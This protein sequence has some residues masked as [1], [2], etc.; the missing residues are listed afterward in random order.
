MNHAC[1]LYNIKAFCKTL[2]TLQT[3]S[4]LDMQMTKVQK[5]IHSEIPEFMV[6]CTVSFRYHLFEKFSPALI[7]RSHERKQ[8]NRLQVSRSC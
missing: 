7:A 5:T 2:H 8:N 4:I 3:S 1:V 6:L